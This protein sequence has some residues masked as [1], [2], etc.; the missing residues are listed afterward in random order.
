MSKGEIVHIYI[1]LKV[2]YFWMPKKKLAVIFSKIQVKR[3]ILGVHLQKHANEIANSEDPD[4]TAPLGKDGPGPH[5]LPRP[6]YPKT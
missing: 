6:V 4:Q 3:Q 5:C 2:S 1:Y